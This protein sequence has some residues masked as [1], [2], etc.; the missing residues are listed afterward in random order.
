MKR[1]AVLL[2]LLIPL[3]AWSDDKPAIRFP[4]IM[5]PVPKP[6]PISPAKL[7]GD[8][9]YC[10]DGDVPFFV[11]PSV[12]G[13]VSIIVKEG[14]FTIYG[15]FYDGTD[16]YMFREFKSKTVAI[17]QP[18][19]VGKLDI[20]VIPVGATKEEQVIRKCLEVDNGDPRP[21]PDPDP[22]PP[23]PKPP[24]PGPSP[25][26]TTGLHVLMVYETG[27][28]HLLS[29]GQREVLFGNKMAE[30]L[31]PKLAKGPDGKTPEWR[32]Y[33]QHQVMTGE[34]QYWKDAMTRPRR[35]IPWIQINDGK[36]FH[37]GPL[38]G[39]VQETIDILKKTMRKP[40]TSIHHPARY[41]PL[42]STSIRSYRC[43]FRL[44][45]APSL[46]WIM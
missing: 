2:L 15:R 44:K 3:T 41:C 34:S 37:E 32:L 45:I 18:S 19:G 7:T 9:L 10:V 33:D 24:E 28:Q 8:M 38:P 1:Y 29:S 25:I 21:P 13:L 4:S 16:G 40:I 42:S 31:T 23:G 39:S 22:K 30:Y 5:Q 6:V 26:P 43:N 14:P 46:Q 27:E 12:K 36:A 35:V 20:L 17:I 11:V